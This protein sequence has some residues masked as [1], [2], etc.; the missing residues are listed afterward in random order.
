M[1]DDFY[2]LLSGQ[3]FKKFCEMQYGDMMQEYELREIEIEILF[4][5]A[6]SSSMRLAK[7][8][9]DNWSLSKSHVSKSVEHLK[10]RGFIRVSQDAEDHR[11]SHLVITDAGYQ[12]IEKIAHRK[13]EINEVLY[14]GVTEEEREMLK[15]VAFKMKNNMC[16]ALEKNRRNV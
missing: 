5:L 13:N 9:V 2:Y 12:L 3:H 8:I 7:E 16:L 6:K 11:C 4:Y 15:R 1:R 10:E 14:A